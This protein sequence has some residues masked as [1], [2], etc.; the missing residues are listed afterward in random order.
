MKARL[1]YPKTKRINHT[2]DYHGTKVADP[3]RWLEDDVRKSPEVAEWVAEENKLTFAYLHAIPQREA[4]HKRLTELW[5]Y[6][7]LLRP[8]QGRRPLLLHQERRPAK[9]VR[10]VHDGRARRRAARAARSQQVV[11]GR[12]RRPGGPGGQ[13]RRQ[14]PR[15][16]RRRGRLRLADLA[17]PRRGHGQ[18]ARRRGEV[19]QVQRR[20]LDHGRQG[21][22]LQPLRRAEGRRDVSEG[23]RSTRRSTTTASARRRPTTCSSTAGPTI[24]TG[25]FKRTSPRTAAISSSPSG[26]APITSTA[27]PTR[28]SASRTRMPV[29]L[30]EDFDNEYSFV[31]NDGPVFYFKTDLRRSEGPAHRHRHAQ[32]GARRTGKRSSPKRR[33]T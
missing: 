17:R 9:P 19:D 30:I 10:A 5:N 12:H 13:R 16:R 21:L 27:S 7:K 26:R 23:Q 22:L 8:L 2:D 14:V 25:A 3:Y 28:T 1:S 29:D 18:G 32:A 4:I 15:L 11:E 24:P 6:E 31:G 33:R 20:V